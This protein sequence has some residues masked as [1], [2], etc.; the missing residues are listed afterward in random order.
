MQE[1]RNSIVN[2]LEL[3]L[4]CPNPSTCKISATSPRGQCVTIMTHCG[5]A[6]DDID[7]YEVLSLLLYFEQHFYIPWFRY[8]AVL[9][10]RPQKACDIKLFMFSN[11]YIDT[12]LTLSIHT[13]WVLFYLQML[14]SA[15]S[16]SQTTSGCCESGRPIFTDPSTGQTICSCQYVPGVGLIGG[17]A[18]RAPGVG[19]SLLASAYA[20]HG[21]LPLGGDP[22]TLCATLVRYN[23]CT[24]YSR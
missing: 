6:W 5:A 4:S 12:V 9:M 1:R 16:P 8:M 2:A 17:A 22:S 3:R 21:Y 13:L 20:A 10:D 7:I 23:V 11:I 24:C 19:D 14:L 15:G 18:S